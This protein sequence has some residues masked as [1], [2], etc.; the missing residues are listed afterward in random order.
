MFNIEGRHVSKRVRLIEM[1]VIPSTGVRSA[2]ADRS[3]WL[4]WGASSLVTGRTGR[5][6]SGDREQKLS[7]VKSSTMKGPIRKGLPVSFAGDG[8]KP[9][10]TL[11]EG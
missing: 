8:A 4:A 5:D 2:A 3:T 1:S 7:T 10:T 9:R 11:A 6:S